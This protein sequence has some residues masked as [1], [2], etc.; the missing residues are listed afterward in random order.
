MYTHKEAV[1]IYQYYLDKVIG[2]VMDSK[3]AKDLPIDHL[4]IEELDDHSFD[5]FCYG[6]GSISIHF[7]RDIASVAEDLKLLSPSEVLEQ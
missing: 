2:K 5:V 6:K 7:F 3:K 1:K 4:K